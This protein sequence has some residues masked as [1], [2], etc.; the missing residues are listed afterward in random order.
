MPVL[1]FSTNS[2]NFDKSNLI[3]RLSQEISTLTGKPEKYVM[4]I[5]QNVN[6]I[7]FDSISEPSAYIEIKSIGGINPKE[8]SKNICTIIEQN[9]DI[10]SDRI[11]I[12]MEDVKASHWG[13]N[14]S[15]FG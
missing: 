2:E 12:Y 3:S 15:T 7:L 9:T 10:R 1:N 13:Y 4:V 14:K 8:I 11:Y 6:T 5:F